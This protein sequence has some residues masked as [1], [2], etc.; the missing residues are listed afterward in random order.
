MHGIVLQ[1]TGKIRIFFVF[2]ALDSR[3]FIWTSSAR[4]MSEVL[5]R[6][7]VLQKAIVMLGK[8][9]QSATLLQTHCRPTA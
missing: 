4:Q 8:V 7:I 1:M 2:Y 6:E 9:L 5:Y 3:S